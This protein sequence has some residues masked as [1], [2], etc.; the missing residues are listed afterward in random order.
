MTPFFASI[1]TTEFLVTLFLAFFQHNLAYEVPAQL[2][3]WGT[4]VSWQSEQTSQP[5]QYNLVLN[6][7][8]MVL[9]D[10]QSPLVLT[11][12]AIESTVLGPSK[13]GADMALNP[14]ILL[15]QPAEGL[16]TIPEH[17]APFLQVLTAEQSR[18]FSK[19]QQQNAETQTPMASRHKE[20]AV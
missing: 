18:V 15:K 6:K 7:Q 2:E 4:Q 20:S 16:L 10:P 5:T 19:Q 1:G 14:C 3:K 13:D 9:V 12:L 11:T 17:S 8:N